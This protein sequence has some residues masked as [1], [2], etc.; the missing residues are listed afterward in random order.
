MVCEQVAN[1]EFLNHCVRPPIPTWNRTGGIT[2]PLSLLLGCGIDRSVFASVQKIL[3]FNAIKSKD[4]LQCRSCRPTLSLLMDDSL[5]TT[6]ERG[7]RTMDTE[8][9]T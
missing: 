2:L 1:S 9:E 3:K 4:S 8:E 6:E 5:K 7:L